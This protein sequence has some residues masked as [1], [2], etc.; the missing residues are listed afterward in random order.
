MSVSERQYQGILRVIESL[1]CS[2]DSRKIREAAGLELLKLLRADHFASFIWNLES[3]STAVR[4]SRV[5]QHGSAE[6]GSL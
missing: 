4:R 3:G 5:H 6:S 2:L 1:N